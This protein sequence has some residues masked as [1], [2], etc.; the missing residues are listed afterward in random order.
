MADFVEQLR[1]GLAGWD[2]GRVPRNSLTSQQVLKQ[3]A[4]TVP[5]IEAATSGLTPPQLITTPS[6]GEWSL[7]EVV[8]H[9]PACADVWGGCMLAIGVE[10]ERTIRAI[11]PLTWIKSTDY[12]ELRF[13]S[14]FGA[15]A[16][17]REDLLLRL[18][19]LPPHE[20]RSASTITG[21]GKMLERTVL[22]YGRW[23]AGHERS[24]MRQIQH[25]VEAVRRKGPQDPGPTAP[26][27]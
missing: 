18:E 1:L 22:F 25:T 14:S 24:H 9:L 15:F 2:D 5:R 10:G 13:R 12:L 23:L 6:P 27:A 20:W 26:Q 16:D 21:A 8:A 11:N 3:L 19:R 7:G 4:E 17:Q